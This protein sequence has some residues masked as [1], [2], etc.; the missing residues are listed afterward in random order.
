MKF[1]ADF[2][3]H[4][5]HSRATSKNLTLESL[6]I[7]AQ[8]KGLT[9]IATGDFTHPVWIED[10]REKL[11]SADNGLYRLKPALAEIC[12]KEVP[13]ACRGDV[14]FMLVTEISNIY[15]KDGR[16]RKNHNLI[17]IPEIEQAIQLNRKLEKIGNIGSDGRPILG[18]DARNLL[19]MTLESGHGAF[20]VP[21]HIWTPWFSMLGSKSG[22]DSLFECFDDLSS[23]IF[24][25][26]TGLSSDPV[27]NWQIS[28]LDQVV[29]ISNSDAHSATKLGREANQFDTELSFADIRDAL[30]HPETNKFLGTT[31]FF[32]EE[33]KYHYDGHRK[34][35]I[36]L[37][38]AETQK[39]NGICPICKKPLTVGVLYRTYETGRQKKW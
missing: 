39:I 20:L 8:K 26:E 6:H 29:L 35:Q 1:L 2:H 12:D 3:V 27:M 23:H 30:K 16:V 38:P 10:I 28:S 34:C 4:S 14:Q 19:E 17:F 24:A 21:A 15:K 22:F 25:V 7:A 5:S 9:V 36:C 18:L 32:P 37:H 13:P 11:I 33:G 31:E